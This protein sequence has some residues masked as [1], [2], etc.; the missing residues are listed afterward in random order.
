MVDW[1]INHD[2]CTIRVAAVHICV[3]RLCAVFSISRLLSY[4]YITGFSTL[5]IR[6]G[7]VFAS[8]SRWM[9][10]FSARALTSL[11][12]WVSLFRNDSTYT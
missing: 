6:F 10:P 3:R 12:C 9:F 2:C 1:C 8:D 4:S 7:S 5:R 11:R